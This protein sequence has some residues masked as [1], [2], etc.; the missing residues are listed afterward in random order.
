[1]AEVCYQSLG[2][3][4]TAYAGRDPRMTAELCG[5]S[6]AVAEPACIRGAAV[7]LVDVSAN[8]ADGLALCR[9]APAAAKQ[10]CYA[11]VAVT[12]YGHLPQPERREALCA[13]VEVDFVATCRTS[14]GL[15]R[16]A[17]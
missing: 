3:D 6:G 2:R 15:Q 16:P 8:P 13:T 11:D 12:M 5:R 9:V 4:L 7:S 1:M 10:G 17:R 14:A